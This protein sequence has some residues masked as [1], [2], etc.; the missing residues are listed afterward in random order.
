MGIKSGHLTLA[1]NNVLVD[2]AGIGENNEKIPPN[3]K[4]ANHEHNLP[5]VN[6]H[7][8]ILSLTNNHMKQEEIVEFKLRIWKRISLLVERRLMFILIVF[9]RV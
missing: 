1:E 2:M 7:A 5:R 8:S 4:V 9:L 3:S 6:V